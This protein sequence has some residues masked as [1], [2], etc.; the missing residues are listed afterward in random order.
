MDRLLTE[1]VTLW[2]VM[3]PIGTLPVFLAVTA[4]M[5]A[6]KARKIA[7]HATII[8]FGVLVFFVLFGQVLLTTMR[9]N[10]A[11]F[12]AA[13]NIVLFLFAL[14]MIFGESKLDE[15]KK[16]IKK[17]DAEHAV[18]PLAIPSIA[19]PGA[20]LAVMTLTD[21][22]HFSVY[23]QFETIA[24]LLVILGAVLLLMLGASRIIA[25]IGTAGASVISRVMGLILASV[26]VDGF[27]KATR[28]ILAQAP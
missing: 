27:V 3:D 12:E 23:E 11:S 28:L 1:L 2:V 4:G 17:T 20:M 9:I 10:I 25:V 5:K 13:G 16:L 22:R 18:F 26:A 19:T 21:N 24:E 8:A 6:A 15:E 7:L 14:T